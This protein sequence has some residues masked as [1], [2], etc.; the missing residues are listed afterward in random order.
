[1]ATIYAQCIGRSRASRRSARGARLMRL[2]RYDRGYS[3]RVFIGKLAQGIVAAGV[4]MPLAKAMAAGDSAR[5]YPE[6]LLSIDNY[7]RGRI[8][9]GGEISAANV[10]L[11]KDL[12]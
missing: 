7:T 2:L 4:L 6:E 3:R 8:A 9:S 5:A 1:M 11:V 12:L 10:E